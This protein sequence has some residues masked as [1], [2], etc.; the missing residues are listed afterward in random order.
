ME[1]AARGVSSEAAEAKGGIKRFMPGSGE[2]ESNEDGAEQMLEQ[3]AISAVR[4]E[5]RR[6]E[7]SFLVV[8]RETARRGFKS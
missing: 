7:T 5:V 6:G 8:T 4:V 1:P 2:L 3:S